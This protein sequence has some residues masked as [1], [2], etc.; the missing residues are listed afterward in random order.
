MKK[1]IIFALLC[2][3]AFGMAGCEKDPGYHGGNISLN[4]DFDISFEYDYIAFG[5]NR[6]NAEGLSSS[7]LDS[8]DIERMNKP[9]NDDTRPLMKD[10]VLSLGLLNDNQKQDFLDYCEST[11]CAYFKLSLI[12]PN[13]SEAA[14]FGKQMIRLTNLENLTD[15]QIEDGFSYNIFYESTILDFDQLVNAACEAL[16][17]SNIDPFVLNNS[18]TGIYLWNYENVKDTVTLKFFVINARVLNE[19]SETYLD[20]YTMEW[21]DIQL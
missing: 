15:E 2:L 3:M 7:G 6:F 9:L 20:Q 21:F 14:D 19:N 8:E 1:K 10:D 12:I 17:V 13:D 11:N 16:S 5:V 4:K 18:D